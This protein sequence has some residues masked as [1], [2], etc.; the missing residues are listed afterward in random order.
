MAISIVSGNRGTAT[1]KTA[2]QTLS[3]APSAA[4]AAGNYGLLA[5][6]VDNVGTAEGETAHV[7]VTD[8]QGH[9]WTRLREQTEANTAAGTG[10]TCALFL[11][12]L[13]NG[14]GTGDTISI[15]LTAN[16]TAKGAGL[17]ELSVA[18]GKTLVLS[19]GGANGSNGAAATSYSV[20]LA[21]LA[22]VPGLYVGMAACENEVDA[23]CTLD[24][25]Y[26]A[27]A[28]GSVGSGTAGAAD[29]NVR[30]RVGTLANTS[31][32]D[33]FDAT[34]LTSADRA[35]IL[36]RL[37]ERL[38]VTFAKAS[39]TD[40]ASAW[41]AQRRGRV[42]YATLSLTNPV[43]QRALE[44]DLARAFAS[45]KTLAYVRASET[46]LARAFTSGITQ[47][48]TGA[49]EAE[50]ARA[51]AAAKTQAIAAAAEVD[52][53]RAFGRA[54]TLAY[55][56]AVETDLARAFSSAAA[57]VLAVASETDLGRAF[58]ATKAR[59]YPG[60]A[61]TDSARSF[62]ATKT[63]LF[64][65]AFEADIARAVVAT[66]TLTV[67][68]AVETDATRPFAPLKT[69]VYLQAMEADVAR[70]LAAAKTLGYSQTIET[71]LA[72][73]IT[74][75]KQRAF[76]QAVETDLGQPF[77]V[78]TSIVFVR[79]SETDMARLF[80]LP[81][82][83]IIGFVDVGDVRLVVAAADARHILAGGEARQLV[84]A[85]RA[86]RVRAEADTRVTMTTAK[87]RVL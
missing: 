11:A 2:D 72:R 76:A 81:G 55:L 66:K 80:T 65:S 64:S 1:E 20:A 10:V 51:F 23:A 60:A 33:T 28:F 73:A 8:S 16:A 3:L 45:T 38:E 21:S 74:A 69:L 85:G 62:T 12:K 14:L 67:A 18:A 87:A 71:D 31:T 39:E 63:L 61:E 26:T 30:A 32:G 53:A 27:L 17:A 42:S 75:A 59:S 35:T 13:T 47:S 19:A 4:L 48:Y 56:A 6:V 52:V 34:G 36:V 58:T 15:A 37:E 46:D 5:V 83:L 40:V 7:S 77:S 44:T 9:T 43:F 68:R 29:S 54:K 78:A 22:N 86:R 24:S 82:V 49:T 25:G 79:A 50:V 41:V 70:A 57:V 84:N